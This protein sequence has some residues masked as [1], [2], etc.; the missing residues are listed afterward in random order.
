MLSII[1]LSKGIMEGKQVKKGW[2]HA[3]LQAFT[4]RRW[5]RYW[6]IHDKE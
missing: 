5:A 2:D 1:A 6:I 4:N 3:L